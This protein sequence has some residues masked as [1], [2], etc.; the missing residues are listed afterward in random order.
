VDLDK[1]RSKTAKRNRVQ[2]KTQYLDNRD[3]L[4]PIREKSKVGKPIYKTNQD[5]AEK[6]TERLLYDAKARQERR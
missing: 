6:V 4:Y 2:T 3:N 5:K 1:K